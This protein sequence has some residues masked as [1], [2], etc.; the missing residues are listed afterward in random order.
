MRILFFFVFFL[1][2]S[3]VQAQEP[4]C[5][6]KTNFAEREFRFEVRAESQP[7]SNSETKMILE[8][9]KRQTYFLKP[10]EPEFIEPPPLPLRNP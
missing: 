1:I 6:S 7:C 2:F 3:C 9:D 4:V 8:K 5:V 10:P